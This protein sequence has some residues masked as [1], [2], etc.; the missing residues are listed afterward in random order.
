MVDASKHAENAYYIFSEYE[1]H[2]FKSRIHNI[3][4]N[5]VKLILRM[6]QICVT[7]F[8]I[9]FLLT[10]VT[11][12]ARAL[13]FYIFLSFYYLSINYHKIGIRSSCFPD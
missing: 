11:I 3:N 8:R 13:L 5:M 4:V 2:L 10:K 6:P 7:V 1:K 12:S 9:V